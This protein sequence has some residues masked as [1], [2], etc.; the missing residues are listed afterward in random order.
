LSHADHL[1]WAIS[2]DGSAGLGTGRITLYSRYP[3]GRVAIGVTAGEAAIRSVT[4]GYSADDPV[5]LTGASAVRFL[6]WDREDQLLRNYLVP[7]GDITSATAGQF[8]LAQTA[9]WFPRRGDYWA[10]VRIDLAS[11]DGPIYIPNDCRA[12]ISALPNLEEIDEED[13][14]SCRENIYRNTSATT[15]SPYQIVAADCGARFIFAN[16][17]SMAG[18]KLP[19]APLA[20]TW[21][22]IQSAHANGVRVTSGAVT[23]LIRFA[24]AGDNADG[25]E[26][27]DDYAISHWVY[28]APN[29]RWIGTT[30]A[31]HWSAA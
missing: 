13:L 25:W 27:V 23:D 21:V 11:G 16:T 1:R 2:G 18:V 8:D 15:A 5:D 4:V 3:R 30:E 28:D 24:S 31:G 14:V 22:R 29:L 7:S 12:L 19:A 9:D 26:T 20:G 6:L 17:S 10:Q